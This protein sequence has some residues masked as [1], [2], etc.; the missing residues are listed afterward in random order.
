MGKYRCIIVDDDDI[1]RLAMV[2]YAKRFPVLEIIGIFKSAE[3]AL[4]FLENQM[5]DILFLDIDMPG[6][7]GLEFRQRTM[8]VPV[9]IFVSS[10]AEHA[11]EAFLLDTLDFIAKPI[12]L[13]RF[14]KTVARIESYMDTHEKASLFETVV[15]QHEMY[16]KIGHEKVKIKFDEIR[17]LEALK[18]YTRI[19]TADENHNVLSSLGTLLKTP[20]FA[21]F[22]RI[23]RSFAIQKKAVKKIMSNGITL[24]D[25]SVLPIGRSYKDDLKLL[26]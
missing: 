4:T 13:D 20:E 14:T 18:D 12:K 22:I 26:Y 21:S 19:V 6:I 9:C 16:I 3:T 15:G 10:H 17:Y 5:P 8:Q 2:S 7:S 24:D 23:H 25:D 11:I 1:D